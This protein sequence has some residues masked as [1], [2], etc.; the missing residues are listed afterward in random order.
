MYFS[1]EAKGKVRA[2][3]EYQSF[4]GVDSIVPEQF[5]RDHSPSCSARGGGLGYKCC[6][7]P[8]PG[9]AAD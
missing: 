5:M 2:H 7:A 6:N 1:Y 8:A 9:S 3:P 4:A